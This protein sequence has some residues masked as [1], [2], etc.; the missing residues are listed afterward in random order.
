MEGDTEAGN[1]NMFQR[2]FLGGLIFQGKLAF[3]ILTEGRYSPE[4]G[5]IMV[6]FLQNIIGSVTT[7]EVLNMLSRNIGGT[8]IL[9]PNG[10]EVE[11]QFFQFA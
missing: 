3:L 10:N 6:K 4:K 1:G 11:G 8:F 9:L 7:R 5:M 2:R